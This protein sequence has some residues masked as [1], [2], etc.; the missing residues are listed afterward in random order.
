MI[1]LIFSGELEQNQ[2]RAEVIKRLATLLKQSPVQI[3]TRLFAGKSLVIKQVEN[4]AEAIKWQAAFKRAGAV[5]AIGEAEPAH[6]PLAEDLDMTANEKSSVKLAVPEKAEAAKASEVKDKSKVEA[7]SLRK[8]PLFVGLVAIVVVGLLAGA[9]YL[10]SVLQPEALDEKAN[11]VLNALVSDELYGVGHVNVANLQAI[12]SLLGS[13]IDA[14]SIPGISEGFWGGLQ[15]ANIQILEQVEHIWVGTF[16]NGKKADVVWVITGEFDT[17]SVQ[18]WLNSRFIVDQETDAGLLFSWL[19][20]TTCKKMP[21]RL[22]VIEKHQIII[23]DPAHVALFQARFAAS[24]DAVIDLAQWRAQSESQLASFAVFVP[25]KLGASFSGMEGLMLNGVGKMASPASGLYFGLSPTVL[26]IGVD[27]SV[28][29]ISSDAAF[30]SEAYGKISAGLDKAK[31]SA[32]IEWPELTALYERISLSEEAHSLRVAIS[33]DNTF[34]QQLGDLVSSFMSSAFSLPVEV[35]AEGVLP[36]EK[37]DENAP[38]FTNTEVLS[39]ADYVEE[40]DKVS[41]SVG[42]FG[43]RIDKLTVDENDSLLIELAV[44]AKGL[45]NLSSRLDVVSLQIKDVLDKQNSSLLSVPTCGPDENRKST[46]LDTISNTE[47]IDGESVASFM[48]S[49]AKKIQ[50]PAGT[51]V[52][53]VGRIH[54]VIDYKIPQQIEHVIL[55]APLAGQ[56]VELHGLKLRFLKSNQGK[57]H[58]EA[59]GNTDALLYMYAKNEKGLPLASQGASWS[60]DKVSGK[61]VVNRDYHGEITSVDIVLVAK[62]KTLSY[63]FTLNSVSPEIGNI[64]YYFPQPS[65]VSEGEWTQASEQVAPLITEFGW[66]KPKSTVTAGTAFLALNDIRFSDSFGFSIAADVYMPFLPKMVNML[67]G[68]ELVI[69]EITSNEGLKYPVKYQENFPFSYDGGYYMNGVFKADEER[70]WLKG[71]INIKDREL[72]LAGAESI[73]GTIT[74]QAASELETVRIP[75][76]LGES[77]ENEYFNLTFSEWSRNKLNFTI[78]G[79]FSTLVALQALDREGNVVSQPAQLNS[80]FGKTQISIEVGAMPAEFE[81][82]LAKKQQSQEYPFSLDLNTEID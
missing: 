62:S 19:N 70:P 49:G 60:D 22:A 32:L 72:K 9:W 26:P 12:E 47:Y 42:P 68:G 28:E 5:L 56:I 44:K 77:F 43:L 71:S 1:K 35:S 7:K 17:K 55:K 2:T 6:T 74:L 41:T 52:L 50:L 14:T 25:K 75:A 79:D 37:I 31:V 34:K 24:S 78:N 39:F 38:L 18:A 4:E 36:I 66:T 53:D 29:V 23:G 20:E 3:E 16:H 81:L 69:N 40:Y 65:V 27:L 64:D 8:F 45:V 67:G 15:S 63:E 73:T 76:N 21:S 59:S 30:V 33:I 57:L 48:I 61:K 11:A 13:E 80:F 54:G 10:R 82:I 58:Y 51:K 46:H